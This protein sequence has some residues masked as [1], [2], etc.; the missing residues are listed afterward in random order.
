TP[1][2]HHDPHDQPWPM[3]TPLVILA[4]ISCVA[5]F[6]PFGNLVTWNGHPMFESMGILTNIE[7]LNWSVACISLA[8]AVVAILVAMKMYKSE[9]PI[10]EKMKNAMP[11]LWKWAHHRFYWD[12]L[13]MFITHKII[14]NGICSPI[15]WFDRHI[16]DGSMDGMASVTQRLSV[17]IRGFQSG[18]LQNYVWIYLIG[19]L[20]L[21]AVTVICIM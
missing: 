18:N 8:V 2:G 15:A 16:I 9:N 10:P 20:L 4:I 19:A 1:E 17:A 11:T 6:V 13:Y 14:F 5:G 7:N 12:E 21:G 3:T